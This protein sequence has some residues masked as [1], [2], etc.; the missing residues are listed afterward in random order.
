MSISF[1]SLTAE[2]ISQL[3][4]Q[5][6]S[7]DNWEQ[8]KVSESFSPSYIHQ[9]FF[10]GDIVLNRFSTTHTLS[11]GM[12]RHSGIYRASLHNCT[13]ED[14]VLIMNNSGF[15]SN[16]HILKGAQLIGVD[17]LS[18]SGKSSFGNGVKALVLNETGGRDVTLYNG[19]SSQIAYILAMY[20]HNP[21]LIASLEG[22]V[23]KRVEESTHKYGV[24]GKAAK[25]HYCRVI[26]DVNIGDYAKLKNVT[27]LENGTINSSEQAL[28]RVTNAVIAKDFVFATGATVSDGAHLT[29]C[30]VGQASH[31]GHQFSAHDSLFFANSQME[32]GEA[33]SV[34]AGPYSVSM[35]KSTLLI[36]SQFSFM[37]AGS[38][39]NQ[40]NHMY[41]LGPIHQ[42]VIE[43][44]GRLASDSYIMW[45]AKVGAFTMVMGRHYSNCD[46]SI[47]PFSYLIAVGSDSYL[48]PGAN[49]AKVGTV[50][51][52]LKWP[53]RD[54]RK[55]KCHD[56]RL[57]F[58]IL[59]PFT[60]GNTVKGLNKLIEIRD[61]YEMS[62]GT[63]FYEGIKIKSSSLNKG[64]IYYTDALNSYFGAL[65]AKKL[66]CFD[67]KTIA[68]LQSILCETNARG[69]GQWVDL[70]GMIVPK[71]EL[72]KLLMQ[73][74]ENVFSSISQFEDALSDIHKCY[75]TYEW[76]WAKY[77]MFDM[78]ALD[79]SHC[80]IGDLRTLLEEWI[81]SEESL[82]K[83]VLSDA[84]KEFDQNTQVGF[85]IDD[86][87]VRVTDFENVRGRFDEHDFIKVINSQLKEKKSLF[88]KVLYKIECLE[89]D[90]I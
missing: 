25:L 77:S 55:D 9:T 27:S 4:K 12:T 32:N 35:H 79:L 47:F 36:A 29:R 67:G 33:C 90:V 50:R 11:G 24:V 46:T 37:N 13:V 62:N 20:R 71:V 87:D 53:K 7:C 31:I 81:L 21:K 63:Y 19:L 64:I 89:Q 85:G 82:C 61:T 58:D 5:G 80:S 30:Y 76:N 38:G 17:Q 42:G 2:E 41:K 88:D 66:K 16:Y 56:D 59:N 72:D 15:I 83:E 54:N 75:S 34:F 8:V 65:L 49:L 40:S 84:K 43:R 74:E 1:R 3:E 60:I 73:V 22:L 45:P 39:S 10:S 6:C 69:L 86:P 14:D 44:G 68:E 51:D 18:I 57:S 23:Q 28:T 70:S 52:S 26:T 48:M 78:K